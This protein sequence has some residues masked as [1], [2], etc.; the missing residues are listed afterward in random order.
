[1]SESVRSGT[2]GKM[3]VGG[4]TA[5][6]GKQKSAGSKARP[7]LG[8]RELYD[9]FR[10]FETSFVISNMLTTFLPPKTAFSLSSALMLVFTFLS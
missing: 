8:G 4:V 5:P 3:Q 2:P 1:M 9:Y 7:A 6:A 10:L